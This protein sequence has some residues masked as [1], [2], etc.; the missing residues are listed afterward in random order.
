MQTWPNNYPPNCPPDTASQPNGVSAYYRIVKTGS[1]TGNDFRSALV[2]TPARAQKAVERE[3]RTPCEV[4]GLSVW[5]AFQHAQQC[6]RLF[7]QLGG[8]IAT[9]VPQPDSGRVQRTKGAFD[10][11]N[12]WWLFSQYD[13]LTAVT[14]V[15]KYVDA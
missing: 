13:P 3:E 2:L 12:T 7:P 8:F 4:A 5:A 6:V 9:L 10:S 15:T 1:P 11:H 14:Q